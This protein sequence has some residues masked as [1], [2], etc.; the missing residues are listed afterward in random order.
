MTSSTAPRARAT[1]LTPRQ[2][3]LA[4]AL[5]ILHFPLRHAAPHR[6]PRL[7]DLCFERFGSGLVL[8]VHPRDARHDVVDGRRRRLR[9]ASRGGARHARAP[10][11]RQRDQ[12]V[13]DQRLPR[14]VGRQVRHREQRSRGRRARCASRVRRRPHGSAYAGALR[15]RRDAR[16]PT[17]DP[18][19]VI[20]TSSRS[21][22]RCNGR[23]ER[24]CKKSDSTT[25][26]ASRSFPRSCWRS[27]RNTRGDECA[28]FAQWQSPS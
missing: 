8:L 20:G 7:A 12:S 21:R 23:P 28:S 27:L 2:R 25:L 3:P 9:R 17:H 10:R 11:G 15:V 1:D 6:A 5:P 24:T 4:R 18:T 13:R 26:S 14:E 16:H 22:P 19:S